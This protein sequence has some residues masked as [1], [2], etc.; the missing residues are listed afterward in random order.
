MT[1]SIKI[2][3][4]KGFVKNITDGLKKDIERLGRFGF[5]KAL[6]ELFT[7]E[8]VDQIRSAAY[9]ED[10]TKLDD[11]IVEL[12]KIHDKPDEVL[13]GVIDG[14]IR[15][16]G[17]TLENYRQ[18]TVE[19][20][21][22][23]LSDKKAQEAAQVRVQET[24]TRHHAYKS[25][26]KQEV[27]QITIQRLTKEVEAIKEK[28]PAQ[29]VR[30]KSITAAVL[31][32]MEVRLAFADAVAVIEKEI[33]SADQRE[34]A[35]VAISTFEIKRKAFPRVR[36][37][38]SYWQ[39]GVAY[40][41]A[42]EV[43]GSIEDQIKKVTPARAKAF[44]LELADGHVLSGGIGYDDLGRVLKNL[45]DQKRYKELMALNAMRFAT[46][47]DANQGALT[48]LSKYAAELGDDEKD[49]MYALAAR[50]YFGYRYDM[51]ESIRGWDVIINA[52]IRK[53]QNPTV[54]NETVMYIVRSLVGF[55][56][57]SRI[58]DRRSKKI[59]VGK[60]RLL[61]EALSNDLDNDEMKKEVE[62]L[63]AEKNKT[64]GIR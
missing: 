22:T 45:G 63:L 57:R 24:I 6:P 44:W 23:R 26:N 59:L 15:E 1:E 28:N 53:I 52:T 9:A 12:K 46:D 2:S 32:F 11:W 61:V 14:V 33:T 25:F 16:G 43:W 3:E 37:G 35:L 55:G 47:I 41:L 7:R 30:E 36:S 34:E 19:L 17:Y 21:I 58:F 62:K 8:V 31:S 27:E 29:S 54:K 18:K 56:E 50:S 40:G 42:E 64:K 39:K 4:D 10:E 20:L 60:A 38:Y 48:E 5:R 13:N 49:A 51:V